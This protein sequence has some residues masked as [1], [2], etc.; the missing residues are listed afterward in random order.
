MKIVELMT[1]EQ[2]KSAFPV[3]REL[4]PMDEAEFLSLL[5][6]MI[7]QG[8]RLLA[9]YEDDNSTA[10][11]ALAGFRQST[12]LLNGRS[13]YIQDLVTAEGHRSKGYGKVLIDYIENIARGNNCDYLWLTS[14]I[15]RNDAHNFY[16]EKGGFKRSSY[17]FRKYLK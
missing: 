1:V 17:T 15:H 6:I 13:I 10:P 2:F 12:T 14:G 8:Y 9:V 16:E 3:M 4:R 7:P 11:V 5:Q